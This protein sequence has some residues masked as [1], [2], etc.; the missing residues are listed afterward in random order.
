MA[1]GCEYRRQ[2]Y[3]VPDSDYPARELQGCGVVSKP[4]A[5]IATAWRCFVCLEQ[6]ICCTFLQGRSFAA[7]SGAGSGGVTSA[8]PPAGSGPCQRHLPVGN[9]VG[10]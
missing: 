8:V 4:Y 1:L 6:I 2:W 5:L 9:V 10:S 3:G 7:S